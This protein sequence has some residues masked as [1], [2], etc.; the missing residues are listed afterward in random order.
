MPIF[1]DLKKLFFGA[2]SIAKH[3]ASKA[4]ELADDFKDKAGYLLE[5]AKA[6]AADPLD[7]LHFKVSVR[8]DS[9]ADARSCQHTFSQVE[10][11]NMVRT[12]TAGTLEDDVLYIM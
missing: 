1:S 3:Q 6:A 5:D 12:V 10:L 4:G 7:H 9:L 8:R 2:K 11:L